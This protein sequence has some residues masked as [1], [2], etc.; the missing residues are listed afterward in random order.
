MESEQI[1]KLDNNN[2]LKPKA[3]KFN[4]F[5]EDII[6]LNESFELENNNDNKEID[7]KPIYVLT[8]ELERGKLEKIK[9]FSDSLPYDLANSFCN[10]HDLDNS[11]F[12]YLKEKIE[13][14]L[15]EYKN[16]KT[17]NLK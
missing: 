17:K 7:K 5:N 13:Y 12:L 11:A 15:E 2:E 10:Q 16:K 14:L 1:K 4:K 9:I 6:I 3:K 8:V